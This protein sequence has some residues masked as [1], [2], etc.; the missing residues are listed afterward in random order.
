MQTDTQTD[1]AN[2]HFAS[3]MPQA[4]CYN[5]TQREVRAISAMYDYCTR[6]RETNV[7]DVPR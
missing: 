5:L 3:P 2:I 7:E 6:D 1:V 4:K